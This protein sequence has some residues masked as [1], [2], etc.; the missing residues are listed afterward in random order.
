MKKLVS[1]MVSLIMIVGLTGCS[2]EKEKNSEESTVI[3]V[4]DINGDV[5]TLNRP[6]GKIFLGFYIENYL[7]VSG[8]FKLDRIVAMSKGETKDL[9]NAM[10]SKYAEIIPNLEG[11]I[12][13]GSIYLDSF[14]MEKLIEAKPDLVILAPYQAKKIGDG[15][16]TIKSLGI[17]VAVVDYNSFTL[18]KHVKST[19][20]LGKLLGKEER[21]KELVENYKSH[22]KNVEDRVK[23]IPEDKLKSVYFELASQGPDT[24]GNSY[25]NSLWGNILK[26]AKCKNIAEEKVEEYGPLNPEYV[27]SSN[28]DIIMFSG[29]T[30]SQ[31]KG[32][33]RFEMGFNVNED[34]AVE[35]M[36]MYLKR[37]GWNN[38]N[39]VKN[40]EVYGFDHSGL[41]TLYDYVYLQYAA[42]AIHPEKFK[43][44]DPMKNLNEFY[45]KYLPV[46]PAG[47]FMIKGE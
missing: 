3:E 17:P 13:T 33:Q 47:T 21:A 32:K 15:I 30:N 19:E 22:I 7:A 41:R 16:N 11:C 9:M 26:T 29:Q 1:I 46:K 24:Y 25:G 23:D 35:T 14:S 39:A 31:D 37:P 8:D 38:L 34:R 36:N 27:I 18:D 10:W 45:E 2:Q 6:A 42:K 5:V 4:E 43:D 44:V 40:K 28:P 12:D 20:I